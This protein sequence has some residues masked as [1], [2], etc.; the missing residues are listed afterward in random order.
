MKGEVTPEVIPEVIRAESNAVCVRS[1]VPAIKNA[2]QDS[3]PARLSLV[4]YP[5]SVL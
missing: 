2:W 3:W 5:K 1:S 4:P